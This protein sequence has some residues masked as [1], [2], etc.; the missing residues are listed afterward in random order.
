MVV[1]DEE[2]NLKEVEIDMKE[3]ENSDKKVAGDKDEFDAV[4]K[5]K[6]L[7]DD[8]D[9]VEL[10]ENKDEQVG[11]YSE[12][13]MLV[14]MILLLINSRPHLLSRLVYNSYFTIALLFY[15]SKNLTCVW[16]LS[17]FKICSQILMIFELLEVMI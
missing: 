10:K 11:N 9:N 12:T 1:S 15:S 5:T 4:A 3:N 17:C 14:T 6:K 8:A 13:L 7:S 16:A 2:N